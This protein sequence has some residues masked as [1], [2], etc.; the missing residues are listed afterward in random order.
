MTDI[1]FKSDEKFY[2]MI[3][4]LMDDMVTE[5]GF[6]FEQAS[7]FVRAELQRENDKR[8][9]LRRANFQVISGEIGLKA[10]GK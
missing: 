2:H 5:H 8:A 9:K 7:T 6:S 1:D 3:K 4:K 10:K